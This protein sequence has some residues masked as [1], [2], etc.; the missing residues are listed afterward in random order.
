GAEKLEEPIEP[1]TAMFDQ[2]GRVM[3]PH[4]DAWMHVLDQGGVQPPSPRG[5]GSE[6]C[7]LAEADALGYAAVL[8]RTAGRPLGALLGSLGKME[9]QSFLRPLGPDARDGLLG[10]W[11]TSLKTRLARHR[12]ETGH[13]SREL[14][15]LTFASPRSFAKIVEKSDADAL[16]TA[17]GALQP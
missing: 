5:V 6:L 12:D 3:T 14:L 15:A 17:F 8:H 2:A 10:Q 7:G 11:S 13:T 16:R 1:S 4:I 9:R